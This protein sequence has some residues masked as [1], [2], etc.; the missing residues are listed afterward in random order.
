MTIDANANA[1][2]TAGS[3]KTVKI[4]SETTSCL[5]ITETVLVCSKCWNSESA[6]VF[7]GKANAPRHYDKCDGTGPKANSH[8]Y[9]AAPTTIGAMQ[10]TNW[11]PGT[12]S[13]PPPKRVSS[14]QKVLSNEKASDDHTMTPV[15][16]D[17]LNLEASFTDDDLLYIADIVRKIVVA[18]VHFQLGSG[19]WLG[20]GELYRKICTRYCT[21]WST[22]HNTACHSPLL[23]ETFQKTGNKCCRPSHLRWGSPTDNQLDRKLREAYVKKPYDAACFLFS[24]VVEHCKSAPKTNL[25][26]TQ[27]LLAGEAKSSVLWKKLRMSKTGSADSATSFLTSVVDSLSAHKLTIAFNANIQHDGLFESFEYALGDSWKSSWKS[28]DASLVRRRTPMSS[29]TL[30]CPHCTSACACT[31]QQQ[32]RTSQAQSC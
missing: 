3:T 9:T 28:S 31:W 1:K 30:S 2:H 6:M 4:S 20:A 18:P 21:G 11:R 25:N 22:A 10:S 5:V 23:C 29:S 27:T 24:H 13:T 12:K 8:K 17:A 14:Q 7:I 32:L 26:A 19:C 16:L 15:Q